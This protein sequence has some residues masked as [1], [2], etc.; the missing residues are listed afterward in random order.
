MFEAQRGVSGGWSVCCYVP[1]STVKVW[2]MKMYNT[3]RLHKQSVL[4]KTV[5]NN[6]YRI[7]QL[8]TIFY[9]VAQSSG[10]KLNFYYIFQE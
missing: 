4:E 3:S 7:Q 2:D 1:V 6:F 9:Y 5:Y 10:A 8:S